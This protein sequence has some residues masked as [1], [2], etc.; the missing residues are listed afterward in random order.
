MDALQELTKDRMY[1]K[2][3]NRRKDGL[4]YK[5]RRLHLPTDSEIPGENE[6]EN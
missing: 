6:S 2:K 4:K 3:R 5:E 1:I